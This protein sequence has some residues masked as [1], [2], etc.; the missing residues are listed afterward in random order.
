MKTNIILF[1]F[2]LLQLNLQAQEINETTQLVNETTKNKLIEKLEE[3]GI[4]QVFKFKDIVLDKKNNIIR[5]QFKFNSDN[6]AKNSTL[7]R[8]LKTDFRKQKNA[9]IRQYLYFYSINVFRIKIP[10]NVL[11]EIR[12]SYINQDCPFIQFWFNED[13]NKFTGDEKER[14]CM[15]DYN[16]KL[17]IKNFVYFSEDII[18]SKTKIAK[19]VYYA[20]LNEHFR[21][22]Y[23]K[24][25]FEKNS[26]KQKFKSKY[27]RGNE[28]LEFEVENL[29]KEVLNDAG[30]NFVYTMLKFLYKKK[31]VPYEHLKFKISLVLNTE[32]NQINIKT[33]IIGRYGSGFYRNSRWET[34]K[35]MDR[36]FPKYINDYAKE[37]TIKIINRITNL[38]NYG[39]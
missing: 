13:T 29:E 14:I 1:L 36:G 38:K 34:M 31:F 20:T 8:K 7:W 32:T 37:V 21:Q 26:K 4:S 19:D 25:G 28:T 18:T 30:E 11:L 9:N 5:V 33:N 23:R 17:N 27:I 24:G 39:K 2:I 35:D 22:I 10:E 16:K 12:Q 6:A 3:T 15:A